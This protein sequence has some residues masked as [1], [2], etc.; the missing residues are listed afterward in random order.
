MVRRGGEE[1]WG[2][3]VSRL[4]EEAQNLAKVAWVQEGR[5]ID[6]AKIEGQGEA[7]GLGTR[8]MIIILIRSIP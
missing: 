5:G 7:H 1:A 2:Q 4:I 8:N 3:K 6:A